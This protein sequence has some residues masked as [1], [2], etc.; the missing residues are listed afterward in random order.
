MLPAHAARCPSKDFESCK[1]NQKSSA[2]YVG[3]LKLRGK[4]KVQIVQETAF[5]L[6][7][8]KKEWWNIK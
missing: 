6:E 1:M 3:H 5:I 8:R 2:K 4:S 7:H